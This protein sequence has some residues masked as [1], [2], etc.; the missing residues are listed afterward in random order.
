MTFLLPFSRRH[1]MQALARISFITLITVGSM[2][3]AARTSS[4]QESKKETRGSIAGRV[5]LEGKPAPRVMVIAT[6]ADRYRTISQS[7]PPVRATTDDEGRYRLTGL[8]AGSYAVLPN[9]PS[10]VV[11]EETVGQ[12]GQ[13]VHVLEGEE[14]EDINFTLKQGGVITGRIAD[15]EG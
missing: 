5:T 8:P 12:L 9:A 7:A 15:A 3:V 1:R 11:A 14:A 6:S 13:M 10:F 4:A 2:L